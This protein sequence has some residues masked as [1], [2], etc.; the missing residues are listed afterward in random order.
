MNE[1]GLKGYVTDKDF[2]MHVLSSFPKEYDVI[3]DGLENHC[4]LSGDDG[5]MIKVIRELNHRYDQ[6]KNENENENEKR[7]EKA[8]RADSKQVKRR[9]HKCG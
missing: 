6:I 8:L 1:F 4:T 2:T 5:L 9:Y 7:K 3:L